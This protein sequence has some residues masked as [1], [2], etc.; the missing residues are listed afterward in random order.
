M[1]GMTFGV[2]CTFYS[3]HRRAGTRGK[4]REQ[5]GMTGRN[6]YLWKIRIFFMKYWLKDPL[7]IRDIFLTY[8]WLGL[9]MQQNGLWGII[10]LL[11]K[12]LLSFAFTSSTGDSIQSRIHYQTLCQKQSKFSEKITRKEIVSEKVL[13]INSAFHE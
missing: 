11:T 8:I 2:S 5:E 7:K 4:P 6:L 3:M 9:G 12:I 10:C 13:T 1:E